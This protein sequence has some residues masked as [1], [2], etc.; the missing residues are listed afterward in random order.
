MLASTTLPDNAGY[1]AAAYLVFVALLVIYVGIMAYK[2]SNIRRDVAEIDELV[3]RRIA[4]ASDDAPRER[5]E[6]VA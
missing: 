6:T 5:E 3:D 1:V 2:L 4:A